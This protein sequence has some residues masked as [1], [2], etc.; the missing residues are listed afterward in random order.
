MMSSENSG[1]LNT[2]API[3][4]ARFFYPVPENSESI[5]GLTD[6]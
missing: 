5:G 4:Y 3:Q 1:N 2:P 6:P